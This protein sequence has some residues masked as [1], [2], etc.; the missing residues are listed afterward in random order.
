V[1]YLGTTS[2]HDVIAM[3][4]AGE[5]GYLD[6]PAVWS[7]RP[8]GV[9]WAADNGCYG[10]SYPGDAK[11]FQWLTASV[12]DRDT[13][14]FATAPDIVG[15]AAGTL[16]R[17]APHLPRIRELG[18]RAALVAQ[19]GLENFLVPYD[20]FDALFIGGTTQW[21]LG[22]HVPKLI[23]RAKVR[24]MH[25]HMGRVNSRKRWR[26]AKSLG[27]DTADGTFLAFAPRTNIPRF[28]MWLREDLP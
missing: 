13:C 16:L 10:K 2:G 17:S 27:C 21:K 15:D 20:S 5:I 11:W 4:H 25:V 7:Q 19:D 18:F 26:Y 8:A 12:P 28:R 14:L 6:N 9:T 22:P 24:G 23:E 3:M 1:L